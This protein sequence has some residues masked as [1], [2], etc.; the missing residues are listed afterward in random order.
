VNQFDFAIVHFINGFAHRSRNF[1]TLVSLIEGSNLLKGGIGLALI[2]W[3]WFRYNQPSSDKREFLLFG[4]V[5]SAFALLFGRALSL[6][7]PFRE[8]PW[9]NVP[10]HF[11]V[12]YSVT[13]GVHSWNSIPSD[14]AVLFFCLASSL[15]MV[16]RRLGVL[17]MCHALFVVCLPRLYVGYHFP[18]DILAGA[19]LGIGAGLLSKFTWLRKSIARPALRWVEIHPAS[20][21]AVAFLWTFEVGEL[22]ESLLTFQSF[23][24]SWLGILPRIHNLFS[25]LTT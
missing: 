21:Y 2:W 20:F 1:D 19:A 14:H 15:W 25:D 11:Q 17:A 7:L 12:P 3:A 9:Q 4:I 22:F 16:S 5:S 6:V 10:Y 8:R 18:T 13:G 24:R 23:A